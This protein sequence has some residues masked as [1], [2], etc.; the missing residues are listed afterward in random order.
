M[1]LTRLP[2]LEHARLGGHTGGNLLLSMMER[3][4]GDFLAAVDGLRTLLGCDGRVWPV[5]DRVSVVCA[6]STRTARQ[7]AARSRWMPGRRRASAIERLWL[8][9]P[10]TIHRAVGRRHQ[11]L[12]RGRHRPRQLLHEPDAD[13]PRA[14]GLQEAISEVDGPGDPRH[15]PA[16]RGARHARVHGGDEVARRMAASSAATSTSSSSTTVARLTTSS[17]G[18]PRSTRSPLPLGDVPPALRGGRR[19][20]SGRR[21]IA[22]HDRRRLAY[23]VW[24]VLAG[25]LLD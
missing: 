4:S 5:S 11:R 23:A 9:P 6:P 14:R 7:R 17:S 24:S 25:R 16:D 19:A 20:T 22:R 8:E 21:E 3:Y 1:L 15:Q 18:T 13:L 10:A 12:R 2:T